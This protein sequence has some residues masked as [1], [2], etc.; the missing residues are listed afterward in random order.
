MLL[1]QRIVDDITDDGLEPRDMLSPERE[2]LLE[3][4]VARGTLREALRYLEMQGV[5]VIKPGPGGGPMVNGVEPRALAST[6]GLLLQLSR[7]PFSTIVEVRQLLEPAM[8]AMAAE[9]ANEEEILALRASVDAMR[10]RLN[11]GRFFLEENRRFHDLVAT[12]SGN[13]LFRLLLASLTWIMD[14]SPLGVEYS[15]ARRRHV[16]TAHDRI[17]QAIEARDPT[18]AEDAMRQHM[19]EFAEYVRTKHRDVLRAPLRWSSV[20]R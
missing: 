12:A 18:R 8:A 19:D 7:A 4:E 11:D 20:T 16:A 1:A 10:E 15:P 14:A 3:Y 2:M 5:V 13:S 17:A 6:I 9:R